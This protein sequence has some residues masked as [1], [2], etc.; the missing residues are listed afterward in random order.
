[1][2][3]LKTLNLRVGVDKPDPIKTLQ[4]RPRAVRIR[5]RALQ[6]IRQETWLANPH[7]T[8]CKTFT[9]YPSGF[10]IDHKVPLSHGGDESEEN[11]QLLCLS[12][13]DKKT[14]ANS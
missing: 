5:G 1:M 11:R 4:T 7:C 13:H 6:R 8:Q 2:S 3:R 9:T 14:L 10:E 12:C